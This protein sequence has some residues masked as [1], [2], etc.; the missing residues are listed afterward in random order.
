MNKHLLL[1]LVEN[2]V[3][4]V[5]RVEEEIGGSRFLIRELLLFGKNQDLFRSV[6]LVLDRRVL[7]LQ[8]L[9]QYLICVVLCK[10]PGLMLRLIDLASQN[11]WLSVLTLES[12]HVITGG[13]L[14]GPAPAA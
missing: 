1:L 7:L 13:Q 2:V 10:Q 11:P 3:E 9:I 4:V 5:V 8:N 12:L 14:F 6:Y